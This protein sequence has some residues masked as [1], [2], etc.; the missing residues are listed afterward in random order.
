MGIGALLLA[1]EEQRLYLDEEQEGLLR[2]IN[3][4]ILFMR[5]E[6]VKALGLKER[7]S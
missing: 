2:G 3:D 1:C 7:K 6:L 5:T 4:D